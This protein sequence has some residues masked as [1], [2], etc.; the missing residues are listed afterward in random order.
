MKNTTRSPQR[1][2][3][4]NTAVLYLAF[5]FNNMK[6]KL[7]F[8][9]IKKV[10]IVTIDTRNL[11]QLQE[12]IRKAKFH[13]SLS[14]AVRIVSCCGAGRDGL[15]LHENLLRLG[16]KNIVVD[17]TNI[18]INLQKQQEEK[19]QIN[20]VALLKL[21]IR[22]DGGEKHLLSVL[23]PPV[24]Q[25]K[26]TRNFNQKLKIIKKKQTFGLNSMGRFSMIQKS[27][28]ELTGVK[29]FAFV[30]GIILLLLATGYLLLNFKLHDSPRW[31]LEDIAPIKYGSSNLK[32][33]ESFVPGLTSEK[34]KPLI[35]EKFENRMSEDENIQDADRV[36]VDNRKDDDS[37]I[38]EANPQ[39]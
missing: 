1:N 27:L 31:G 24:V 21:L 7:A 37:E 23:R 29:Q 25:N 34:N 22:Y 10:G 26:D 15:W 12:A 13:F 20:A 32:A 6:W 35:F 33:E 28:A 39:Y 2:I 9:D 3:K 19:V 30:T 5:E 11:M 17:F 18:N 36:K 4:K 8:S 14:N 38:Q 16:I